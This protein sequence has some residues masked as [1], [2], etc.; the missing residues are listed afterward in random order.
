VIETP[1]TLLQVQIEG[2]SRDSIELLKSVLGKAPEPLNAVD[3]IRASGE[4]IGPMLDA[5]AN[6]GLKRGLLQS[7]TISA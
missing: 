6:N 4:H 3:V 1:F 2:L 5:T 7:G